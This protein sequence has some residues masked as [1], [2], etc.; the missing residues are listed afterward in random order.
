MSE[1]VGPPKTWFSQVEVDNRAYVFVPASDT[2]LALN[3]TATRVW[4]HCD[5]TKTRDEVVVHLESVHGGTRADV[6]SAV[7]TALKL[8]T[9]VGLL[10]RPA[11]PG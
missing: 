10:T 2:F 7:D 11:R 4:R 8:L 6:S 9:S 3:E 1:L 5:G